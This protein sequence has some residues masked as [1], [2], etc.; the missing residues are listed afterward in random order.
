[1]LYEIQ[2]ELALNLIIHFRWQ[3]RYVFLSRGQPKLKGIERNT[4]FT[5][6]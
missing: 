1:M 5:G 4:W 6:L 3:E 2:K